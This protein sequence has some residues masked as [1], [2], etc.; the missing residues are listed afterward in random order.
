MCKMCPQIGRMSTYEQK[1]QQQQTN[2]WTSTKHAQIVSI[3][4]RAHTQ[5]TCMHFDG[6]VSLNKPLFWQRRMV[7]WTGASGGELK[8]KTVTQ[9]SHYRAIIL[10][11]HAIFH[12]FE[13]E[14][15]SQSHVQSIRSTTFSIDSDFHFICIPIMLAD[16]TTSTIWIECCGFYANNY[17]RH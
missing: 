1:K 13:F 4:P 6:N 12:E 14:C 17:L 8:S 5:N 11:R 9:Y 15:A 16:T 7:E 10:H 3:I 2:N